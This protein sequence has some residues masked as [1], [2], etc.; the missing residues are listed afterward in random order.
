[1][2]RRPADDGRLP[3]RPAIDRR[4]GRATAGVARGLPSGNLHA[5]MRLGLCRVF[6]DRSHRARRPHR[7]RHR[8]RVRRDWV[9]ARRRQPDVGVGTRC[10]SPC[11]RRAQSR[12]P[13]PCQPDVAAS[14]RVERADARG[15]AL[16]LGDRAAA[17]ARARHVIH[18]RLVSWSGPHHARTARGGDLAGLRQ[19]D[20]YAIN[21]ALDQ[22]PG[23]RRDGNAALHDGICRVV[24]PRHRNTHRA[25]GGRAVLAGALY[26]WP[27]GVN[28]LRWPVF[29]PGAPAGGLS[30]LAVFGQRAAGRAARMDDRRPAGRPVP[31]A[32]RGRA[33]PPLPSRAVRRQPRAG[34]AHRSGQSIHD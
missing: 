16:A 19:G 26:R 17:R 15:P 18:R 24:R 22:R 28:T 23:L 4:R 30:D 25:R 33:R 1:M 5:G 31:S 32:A 13:R 34:S 10:H 29:V 7:A 27:F 11:R 20:A 8:V 6:S 14:N 9:C 12:A 21:R 3:A 2:A